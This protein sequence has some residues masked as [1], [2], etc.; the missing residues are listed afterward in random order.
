MQ[1]KE[2]SG[3]SYASTYIVENYEKILRK[4]TQNK[5]VAP[6]KVIDLVNDVF[7]SLVRDEKNGL[8]YDEQGLH[9]LEEFIW[10][11]LKGYSKNPRYR[12]DIVDCRISTKNGETKINMIVVA[13]SSNGEDEENLDSFQISYQNASTLDDIDSVDDKVSL[14]SI[15]ESILSYQDKVDFNI[16]GFL[17]NLNILSRN[18]IN[19]SILDRVKL[20]VYMYRELGE[21][22][23]DVLQFASKNRNVYDNILHE[24]LEGRV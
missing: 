4:V 14:R 10:G 21:M 20:S 2:A 8:G 6:D 22:I 23:K 12:G 13:S 16:V 11:R 17:R 9:K 3:N 24:V 19:K 5:W 1:F 7:I 18:D 15:L